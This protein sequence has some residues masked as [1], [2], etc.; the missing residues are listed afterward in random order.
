MN[1]KLN[2]DGPPAVEPYNPL[3]ALAL[4]LRR[5]RIEH[6]FARPGPHAYLAH[7]PA[8]GPGPGP[9]RRLPKNFRP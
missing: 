2:L 8:P 1:A 9:K 6:S 4:F 7:R 3:R 5:P